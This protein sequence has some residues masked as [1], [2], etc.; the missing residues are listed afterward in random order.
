MLRL[1]AR[2]E[3]DLP[4]E[5]LRELCN[6]QLVF[7]FALSSCRVGH[8]QQIDGCSTQAFPQISKSGQQ[9]SLG[10][11]WPVSKQPAQELR[12]KKMGKK[13]KSST[14]RLR[15]QPRFSGPSPPRSLPLGNSLRLPSHASLSFAPPSLL[16]CFPSRWTTP[17]AS[18]A[19]ERAGTV[20]R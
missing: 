6:G 16:S 14:A 20:P 1:D 17:C 2:T 15:T 13:T 19:S 4:L 8:T 11:H 7:P 5:F 10:S 12:Q 3:S 9:I 18:V